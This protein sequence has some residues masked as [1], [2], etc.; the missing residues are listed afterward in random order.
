MGSGPVGK[1]TRGRWIVVGLASAALALLAVGCSSWGRGRDLGPLSGED[2][3]DLYL[4]RA[5]GT[6]IHE[7]L[8]EANPGALRRFFLPS[9]R[10]GVDCQAFYRKVMG[11]P[12]GAYQ[13][14]FWEMKL[15]DVQYEEGRQRARTALTLECADQ[16]P[17]SGGAGKFVPLELTWVKHAGDWYLESPGAEVELTNTAE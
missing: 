5:V 2:F 10:S 9:A 8:S 11:A 1:R 7:A 15:L 12:P 13:P 17:G 3:D 4:K 16:R 14:R 6:I